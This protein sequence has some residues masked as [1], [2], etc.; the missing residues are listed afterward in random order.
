MRNR[1]DLSQM[2]VEERQIF[3]CIETIEKMAADTRLTNCQIKLGQAKDHLGNF[4]DDVSE[5]PHPERILDAPAKHNLNVI[6]QELKFGRPTE[7]QQFL[8][9]CIKVLESGENLNHI[10]KIK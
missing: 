1:N 2:T 9:D 5:P 3:D 7:S 4:I 10:S 8:D 6:F